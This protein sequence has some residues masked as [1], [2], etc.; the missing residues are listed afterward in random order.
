MP[1]AKLSVPS[2]YIVVLGLGFVKM[3]D[4]DEAFRLLFPHL[5]PQV[6][7]LATYVERVW[8]GTPGAP[9]LFPRAMWNV[10]EQ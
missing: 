3:E 5:K 7:K 1:L 10:H 8:M 4:L 2:I 9:P 6:K